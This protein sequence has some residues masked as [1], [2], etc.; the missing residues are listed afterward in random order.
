MV[1]SDRAR[2]EVAS[3]K[4]EEIERR[5]D[6]L[7][8]QVRDSAERSTQLMESLGEQLKSV[9]GGVNEQ[10]NLIEVASALE[11]ENDELKER[12]D[13]YADLAQVGMALG[14][15][16][17]EFAGQVRNINRGLDALRPWAI[18]NRGVEEMYSKLRFSFEHLESYLQLF[19]PLNR[20]LQRRRVP[21]SGMEIDEFVRTVFGPRF[22]R[23]QVT[24]NIPEEFSNTTIT[25]FPSTI[26]PVFA[27]VVDNAIHWLCEVRDRPRAITFSAN[28]HSMR[29]ENTGPGV[30]PRDAETMFEFGA[31]TKPGGRGMGLYLSREALRKE[32]MDI[33]LERAGVEIQPTFVIE[34]PA[35]MIS[36]QGE[37]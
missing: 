34:V 20:R 23:H 35:S 10:G 15:V 4:P 31:T 26:L 36:M 8:D 16:Q 30:D 9:M 25:T 17:H 1:K 13:Q 6:K 5:R 3:L 37:D 18:R 14:L 21:V 2:T 19:V 28:D 33:S 27:N 11:T 32:G 22:E 24:L 29:I 12:V 7:I